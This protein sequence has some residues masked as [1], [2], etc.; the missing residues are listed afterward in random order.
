MPVRW[1]RSALS[2][3]QGEHGDD[4]VDGLNG[5]EVSHFSS[6]A[7]KSSSD[8]CMSLMGISF[9]L[10]SFRAFMDFL[11]KREKKVIQGPR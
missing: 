3:F 10:S 7:T 1:Q 9:A 11:G 4:G 2:V 5:E 6:S 8:R